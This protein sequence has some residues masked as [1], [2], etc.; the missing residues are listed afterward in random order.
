MPL[1]VQLIVFDVDGVLTDGVLAYDDRGVETK[2]FHVRDGFAMKAAMAVGLKVAVL[3]ARSSP[4]VAVRM[5]ELKIDLFMQGC[6]NKGVGIETLAQRAGVELEQVAYLGDDILDLP[7]MVRCRYPMA[8]AD[9]VAEVR[10]A[11]KYVTQTPGGRGAAREAIEHILK[12]QK[13]W[14]AVIERFAI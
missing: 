8:V 5:A 12:A 10:A 13:K 11:A 1:P 6:R 4:A 3:T 7:A 9:G 2:R 14:D